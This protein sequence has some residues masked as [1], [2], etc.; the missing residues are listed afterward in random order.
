MGFTRVSDAHK[1]VHNGDSL[2]IE[3]ADVLLRRYKAQ[4]IAFVGFPDVGKTTAAVMLYELAKRRRLGAYRF[5][6]SRT[7][8]GFQE[9]THLAL[10]SSGRTVPDTPRTQ[11]SKPAS[12]LHLELVR[13]EEGAPSSRLNL[14]L[15]DRTG[16]DFSRA[17]ENPS[18]IVQYPEIE[19]ANCHV[20]L[21]DGKRLVDADDGPR[22]L[23]RIRRL[24]RAL[25][26][27]GAFANSGLLQVALTKNDEVL[28][29][30]NCDMALERFDLIMESARQHVPSGVRATQHRLAARPVLQNVD[31]GDGLISMLSEWSP[32]QLAQDYRMVVPKPTTG[33]MYDRLNSALREA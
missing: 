17:I 27:N 26:E 31:V 4:V 20:V 23:N 1:V 14:L 18:L 32:C 5:C 9:R 28:G 3:E 25:A 7:I 19:R 12:F 33:R 24:I 6:S 29:S 30:P 11:I 10:V 2:S 15:S 21:V 8:R 22:H 16:E 13:Q